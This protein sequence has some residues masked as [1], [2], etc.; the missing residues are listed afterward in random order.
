LDKAGERNALADYVIC[1]EK[2]DHVALYQFLKRLSLTHQTKEHHNTNETNVVPYDQIVINYFI[3]DIRLKIDLNTLNV[4]KNEFPHVTTRYFRPYVV[5][6]TNGSIPIKYFDEHDNFF[7]P[8]EIYEFNLHVKEKDVLSDTAKQIPEAGLTADQPAKLT[9]AINNMKVG[10]ANSKGKLHEVA[11]QNSLGITCYT[12]IDETIQQKIL[13]TAVLSTT[14]NLPLPDWW[15]TY[16]EKLTKELNLHNVKPMEH[17]NEAKA[18]RCLYRKMYNN[19]AKMCVEY[20]S[21]ETNIN[22]KKSTRF[23]LVRN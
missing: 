22:G 21:V 12:E 4:I 8:A 18:K 23:E 7:S 14:G 10:V 6:T 15:Y 13:D 1:S 17:T 16:Y 9:V 3:A 5:F 11:M 19:F 2:T 20:R